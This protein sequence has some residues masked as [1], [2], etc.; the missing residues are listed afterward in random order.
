[1]TH[2]Q[3]Q[4][5]RTQAETFKDFGDFALALEKYTE[6]LNA[7]PQDGGVYCDIAFTYYDCGAYECAIENFHKTLEYGEG[8]DIAYAHAMLGVCYMSLNE[9]CAN[10]AY[11]QKAIMHYEKVRDE[12]EEFANA[13]VLYDLAVAYIDAKIYHKAI[14]TLKQVVAIDPSLED[15]WSYLDTLE[16]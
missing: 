2:D 5:L 6:I 11:V 7:Y 13:K 16:Y 8:D 12:Y 14:I 10:E 9:E 4:T 15:A 3:Y 1:M